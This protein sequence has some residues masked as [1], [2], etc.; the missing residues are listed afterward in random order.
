MWDICVKTR[1]IIIIYCIRCYNPRPGTLRGGGQ[2]R[3][4]LVV[5]HTHTHTHTHTKVRVNQVDP[6]YIS[7]DMTAAI[8][9]D[10]AR[11]TALQVYSFLFF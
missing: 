1:N 3:V 2:V 4:N 7:T 8:S 10:H 9:S 6:G 5:T 11:R